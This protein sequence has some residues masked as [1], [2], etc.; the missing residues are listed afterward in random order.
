M[1]T[2]DHLR[3]GKAVG[4][5]VIEHGQGTAARQVTVGQAVAAIVGMPVD[6]DVVHTRI[7]LDEVQNDL[8]P[9]PRHLVQLAATAREADLGPLDLVEI[10]RQQLGRAGQVILVGLLEPH[11]Q[12]AHL[13]G[14]APLQGA[15]AHHRAAAL[16]QAG[17]QAPGLLLGTIEGHI[18]ARD[19][20]HPQIDI[21]APR[22]PGCGRRQQRRGAGTHPA[23]ARAQAKGGLLAGAAHELPR[24]EIGDGLRQA[25]LELVAL[26][27]PLHLLQARLKGHGHGRQAG[28]QAQEDE[29]ALTH[30]GLHGV[31]RHSCWVSVPRGKT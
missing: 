15:V 16:Q 17:E 3:L 8:Q 25:A 10:H 26:N 28:E 4:L 31:L 6:L 21:A 19:A 30:G 12:Q 27:L 1:E 2:H 20:D 22:L 29:V 18:A 23:L 9:G 24:S 13:Q 5:E 7:G 14:I 11:R